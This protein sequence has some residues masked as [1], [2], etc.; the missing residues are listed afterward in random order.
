MAQ[1]FS[2]VRFPH[3]KP[4]EIELARR[5]LAKN[6]LKGTWQFSVPLDTPTTE[7]LQRQ[8]PDIPIGELRL[9]GKWVDAVC[10][11]DDAVWL[12]EFSERVRDSALGHM[13]TYD[14]LYRIQ[15]KPSKPVRLMVVARVDDPAVRHTLESYGIEWRMV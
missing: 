4:E 5:F 12:I 9:W 1:D 3:Y 14:R 10:E 11:A 2:Q 15:Y 13:L 8:F 6:E 7:E